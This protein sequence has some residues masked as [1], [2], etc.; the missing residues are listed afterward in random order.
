MGAPFFFVRQGLSGCS[1]SRGFAHRRGLF[2]RACRGTLERTDLLILH[3]SLS[4]CVPGGTLLRR[5]LED[6]EYFGARDYPEPP[7][8]HGFGADEPPSGGGLGLDVPG[9][10]ALQPLSAPESAPFACRPVLISVRHGCPIRI[11]AR[12]ASLHRG[13]FLSA[14]R[15]SSWL[16]MVVMVRTIP[17]SRPVGLPGQQCLLRL[18]AGSLWP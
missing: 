9:Y 4:P 15:K 7:V 5:T 10:V 6:E 18:L 13:L 8:A 1:C 16:L 11:W 12:T 14:W 2:P 17:C 3:C